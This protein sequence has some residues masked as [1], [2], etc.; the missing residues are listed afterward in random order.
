[1]KLVTVD[2]MVAV[3]K[4]ADRTGL[5]YAMMM[6]NAGHGLAG[7]L[8]ALEEDVPGRSVT[9]M[10]GPGNNGGDALV[11]LVEM[12]ASGWNTSAYLVGR[13]EDPLVGRLRKAGG[14]TV[15]AAQDSDRSMLAE[16]LHSTAVLLDGLLGTGSKL[17]L[18]GA[19]SEV[20]AAANALLAQM[21]PPPYTVAVDCPSGINCDTGE[22]AEQCIPADL[23]VTMAAV[24]QGLLRFPA[25]DYVGDLQ[26]IDIGL[27]TDHPG[28]GD[29]KVDVAD[30]DQVGRL[31]PRRPA[32]SHKGTFGTAVVVAGSVNY[33][34]AALLAGA[35]AYRAGAGLVTLA[36]PS[37]LHPALAGHLPEATWLLLP[38]ELGVISRDAVT[39]LAEKIAGGCTAMLIGPGL[40]V[41]GTTAEFVLRFLEAGIGSSG[42]TTTMGFLGAS[43]PP[44]QSADRRLPPMVVDADGLK[45]VSRVPD[46]TRRLPAPSVLTPH[47]GEMAVLTGIGIDEIQQD[48]TA[49]ATKYAREWGHVVVLKGAFTVIASPSGHATV[50]PVATA[51]LARAG[52]GDVLAGLIVGL[53]AQGVGS[54]EAAVSGAWIHAQAGLHAA[55]S[56]GNEASVLAGDVLASVSAVISH[57][58]VS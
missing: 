2:Q 17:P 50:I 1:M 12:A 14:R 9:G 4:E 39:V 44:V 37:V 26:V 16:M 20:M 30:A 40:G 47:P 33:T 35:A 51:A 29:L 57:L 19:V 25:F 49:V 38:H 8:L 10:V 3:E 52:T 24:K 7:V 54:Y 11:A 27:P 22:A 48:R 45:L 31:L 28:L 42:G 5:T 46:W 23:T 34:G 32:S 13:D 53:R 15:N 21:D 6:N 41:E 18:R 58:S 55:S 56:V 36:V 43:G